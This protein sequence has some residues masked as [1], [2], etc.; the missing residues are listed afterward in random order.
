MQDQALWLN[1][2]PNFTLF[3]LYFIYKNIDI[4]LYSTKWYSYRKRIWSRVNIMLLMYLSRNGHVAMQQQINYYFCYISSFL[5]WIIRHEIQILKTCVDSNLV[6][7]EDK[8]VW[9]TLPRSKQF[10]PFSVSR[11]Q[12]LSP[13]DHESKKSNPFILD[14]YIPFF[15]FSKCICSVIWHSTQIPQRQSKI[16]VL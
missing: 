13:K 11:T 6:V 9:L 12:T 15:I 4:M 3:I 16:S 2:I 8:H 5:R 1:C 7:V 14:W 10:L